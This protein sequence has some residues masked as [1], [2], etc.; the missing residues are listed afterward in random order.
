M[1]KESWTERDFTGHQIQNPLNGSSWSYPETTRS[2]I[3]KNFLT[4]TAKGTNTSIL[5]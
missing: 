3:P 5:L 2:P 1:N 4:M